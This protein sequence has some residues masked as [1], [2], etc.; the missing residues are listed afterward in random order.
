MR[1]TQPKLPPS[2]RDLRTWA[3]QDYLSK[4]SPEDRKYLKRFNREYYQAKDLYS[5][6]ALHN[7][8]TLRKKVNADRRKADQDANRTTNYHCESFNDRSTH[9]D[10]ISMTDPTD[11]LIDAIDNKRQSEE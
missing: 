4:L 7:T 8:K 9:I 1:K 2:K 3:D 11:A 10:R 6:G 5:A